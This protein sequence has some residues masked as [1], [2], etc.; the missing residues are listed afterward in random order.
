M[1]S[2]VSRRAMP[3]TVTPPK[4]RTICPPISVRLSA[5]ARCRFRSK[6]VRCCS[7][8]GRPSISSSIATKPIAA[9]S[10]CTS[11]GNDRR[12]ARAIALVI[13]TE[14]AGSP[15]AVALLQGRDAELSALYRPEESFRIPIEK[16]VRDDVIFLMA[17]EN[18][19]AAGC[20]ALQLHSGYGELKSMYVIPAARGM[21]LVYTLIVALEHIVRERALCDAN[22]RTRIRFPVA[23]TT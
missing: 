16:H 10:C 4:D 5:K 19:I 17:R 7:A 1:P 18:G 21:R 11:S 20:G 22:H 12:G 15:E 23:S 9:P 13:T 2:I 6:A 3:V 8:P 14:S